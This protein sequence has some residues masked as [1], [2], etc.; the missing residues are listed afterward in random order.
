MA[1]DDGIAAYVL[2]GR[3]FF[4]HKAKG[5][6]LK[7]RL[8]S[9]E[10]KAELFQRACLDLVQEGLGLT[11]STN[12]VTSNPQAYSNLLLFMASCQLARKVKNDYAPLM[13]NKEHPEWKTHLARFGKD[14]FDTLDIAIGYYEKMYGAISQ[15]RPKAS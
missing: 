12:D 8:A 6:A 7:A 14:V 15:Q 5:I 13:E 9:D 4:L 3:E 2:G 10:Q 1:I 11:Y